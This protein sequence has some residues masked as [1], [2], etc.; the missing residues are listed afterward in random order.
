[1]KSANMQ[2]GWPQ[3]LAHKCSHC[4]AKG[5]RLMCIE[6][7]VASKLVAMCQRCAYS[8]A[9]VLVEFFGDAA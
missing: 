6:F 1:M 9:E 4:G 2:E 5:P 8:L 3:T 7:K